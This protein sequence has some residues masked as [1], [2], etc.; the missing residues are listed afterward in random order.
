MGLGQHNSLGEYCGPHTAFSV[1][2]ILVFIQ[3]CELATID[4]GVEHGSLGVILCTFRLVSQCCQPSV[5]NTETSII[6]LLKLDYYVVHNLVGK[7]AKTCIFS[8]FPL[9]PP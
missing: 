5:K 7:R 4:P 1:F 6:P 2:L 9:K 8:L 3:L